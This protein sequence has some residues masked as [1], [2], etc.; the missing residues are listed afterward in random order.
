MF[1]N[2]SIYN[3]LACLSCFRSIHC[4]TDTVSRQAFSSPSCIGVEASSWT[5]SNVHGQGPVLERIS[6]AS[7]AFFSALGS[8]DERIEHDCHAM[9]GTDLGQDGAVQHQ[10]DSSTLST[11][12]SIS[13]VERQNVVQK[14]I[15]LFR[16]HRACRASG[17][18]KTDHHAYIT[19]QC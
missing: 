19:M 12:A 3:M 9:H 8:E 15:A 13:H 1:R 16:D 18:R 14:V 6:N 11:Q 4:E 5:N 7:S 2:V 17:V 10:N